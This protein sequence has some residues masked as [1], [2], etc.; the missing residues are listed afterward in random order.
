MGG[1]VIDKCNLTLGKV[2][3]VQFMIGSITAF[4]NL[5]AT[6]CCTAAILEV[7]SMLVLCLI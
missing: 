6:C 7:V 5:A 2:N 4:K 3:G 1:N